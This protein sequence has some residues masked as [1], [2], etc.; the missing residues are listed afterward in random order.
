MSR[1]FCARFVYLSLS[2]ARSLLPTCHFGNAPALRRAATLHNQLHSFL[3][4]RLIPKFPFYYHRGQFANV[5]TRISYTLIHRLYIEWPSIFPD[6]LFFLA[7]SLFG[8]RVSFW[9][10]LLMGA[11]HIFSVL[12]HAPGLCICLALRV[13]FSGFVVAFRLMVCSERVR[14]CLAYGARPC[15]CVSVSYQEHIK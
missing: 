10:A 15:C 12:G 6:A 3:S 1:S 2:L 4:C 7:G 14:W 8:C 9:D 5:P 13:F 11:V